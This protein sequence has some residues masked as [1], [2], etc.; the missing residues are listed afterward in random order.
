MCTKILSYAHFLQNHTHLHALLRV[1]SAVKV[2]QNISLLASIFVFEEFLLRFDYIVFLIV[3]S[4]TDRIS[5]R[6]GCDIRQEGGLN[7]PN[8]LPLDLP[9]HLVTPINLGLATITCICM[10]VPN[11]GSETTSNLLSI[12]LCLLHTHPD[13]MERYT[14]VIYQP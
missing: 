3:F 12:T 4:M 2:S 7:K 10:F 8:K 9:L 14:R 1:A 11:A 5:D 6:L 13:I